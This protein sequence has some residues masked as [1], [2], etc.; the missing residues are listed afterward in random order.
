MLKQN[1]NIKAAYAH[2]LSS[3]SSSKDWESG[4]GKT[5]VRLPRH[6]P[7]MILA[8]EQWT[9]RNY[10]FNLSKL[11]SSQLLPKHLFCCSSPT[12]LPWGR[13][14]V[15]LLAKSSFSLHLRRCFNIQLGK[16]L[17]SLVWPQSL[18]CF[19]PKTKHRTSWGC[20]QTELSYYPMQFMLVSEVSGFCF[21]VA[22]SLDALLLQASFL[23]SVQHFT[24]NYDNWL[25]IHPV[26]HLLLVPSL[27]TAIHTLFECGI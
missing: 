20:S 6:I 9:N 26:Y 18:P 25:P 8:K 21:S 11:L 4:T 5:D 16:T 17:R 13:Q 2:L 24:W 7:E 12:F 10:P 15:L 14:A 22:N 27:V 3:V 1:S 19:E 23:P